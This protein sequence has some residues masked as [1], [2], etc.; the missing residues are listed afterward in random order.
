MVGIFG[1]AKDCASWPA[2]D[3][4]SYR[5]FGILLGQEGDIVSP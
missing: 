4:G 2:G 1:F 5:R 3:F